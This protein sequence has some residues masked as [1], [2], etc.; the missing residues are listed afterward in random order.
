MCKLAAKGLQ[1]K[2]LARAAW[3][4]RAISWM[5]CLAPSIPSRDNV[6]IGMALLGM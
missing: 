6:D 5:L 2:T 1:V 3:D 4:M